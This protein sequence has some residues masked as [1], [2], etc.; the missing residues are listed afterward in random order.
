MLVR[1]IRCRMNFA[2]PQMLRK[3]YGQFLHSAEGGR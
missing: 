3:E 2:L 1:N